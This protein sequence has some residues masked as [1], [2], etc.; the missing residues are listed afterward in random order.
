VRRVRRLRDPRQVLAFLAGIAYVAFFVLRPFL[1]GFGHVP[2]GAGGLSGAGEYAPAV[3]LAIALGLAVVALVTWIA[4]SSRPAFR[5]SEAEI[6]LLFPAPL[7]RR[8]ILDFALL[9]QQ[10]G[11]LVGSLILLVFTALR[12]SR[13][14]ATLLPRLFGY[15][16]FLTLLDLHMKGVSLWKARLAELPAAA[17][18]RR[19][20]AALLV[21]AAWCAAVGIGLWRAWQAAAAGP[22]WAAG[23]FRGM[24][25]DLARAARGGLAGPALAPFLGLAAP[26]AATGAARIGGGLFF[27]ALLFLHYE[28]VVRSSAR[29]EEAALA[30]ARRRVARGLRRANWE[31]LSRL[32]RARAPFRLEAAPAP[33]LAITWKNLLLRG[34]TPLARLAAWTLAVLAGLAVALSGA[35]ALGVPAVVVGVIAG[36]GF[37]FMAMMP[38]VAGNFLRNDLHVDFQHLETL[39]AWPVA[40][41]RL[42]AAEILAP[43]TTLLWVELTA[44]GVVAAAA[45]AVGLAG[46][47]GERRAVLDTLPDALLGGA[48]YA[49]ALAAAL[50]SLAV[51]GMAVGLFSIALQNLGILLFPGWVPLGYA[52]P[53]G[54]SMLGQNLVVGLGRLIGLALGA[55]PPLLVG[56]LVY[57]LLNLALGLRLTAWELPLLALAVALPFLAEVYLMVRLAGAIWD[58]LDPSQELLDPAG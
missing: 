5:L 56:G 19:R 46:G 17:A 24:V 4:A 15:W 52:I 29:F 39:R 58:R 9:K 13:S 21:G 37:V 1:V 35:V 36:V 20:A 11:I 55:I 50:A 34:R 16:A 22:S 18:R 40:G 12:G 27:L 44:A 33:E 32:V 25:L 48:H 41:W 6:H 57:A 54:T 43:A 8:Q 42:V 45:L 7:T 47:A 53:R 30:R 38:L 10:A 31:G 26:V 23:D 3:Q 49:T 14:P 28:W 2:R 51:L